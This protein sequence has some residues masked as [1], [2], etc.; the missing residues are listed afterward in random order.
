MLL[1]SELGSVGGRDQR[2][3]RRGSIHSMLDPFQARP[4]ILPAS[5]PGFLRFAARGRPPSP[6]RQRKVKATETVRLCIYVGCPCTLDVLVR[7]MS[8]YVGCPL[9]RLPAD[10]LG[11]ENHGN[12]ADYR[13]VLHHEIF[14]DGSGSYAPAFQPAVVALQGEPAG[15]GLGVE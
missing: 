12:A 13:L 10:A 1:R 11:N 2:L 3:G 15:A 5:S 4:I 9:G 8:L 7:W 6:W 14:A